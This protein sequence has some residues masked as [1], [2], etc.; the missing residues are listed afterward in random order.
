MDKFRLGA[1]YYPE[2]WS[3]KEWE[4]DFSKMEAL[5]FNVVRMG[6]AWL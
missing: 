3:E 4:E 6:S 1:S 2:W 5:G